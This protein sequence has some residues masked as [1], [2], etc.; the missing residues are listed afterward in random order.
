LVAERSAR[1]RELARQMA[2]DWAQTF[3]GA[4]VPV[5]FDRCTPSGRLRGYTDRYVPLTATGAPAHVG[6]VVSVQAT[7]RSA[8]S[9]LGRVRLPNHDDTTSTT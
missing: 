2:A 4:T 5:L 6:H 8:A 1:L 9:L 7:A 3:V